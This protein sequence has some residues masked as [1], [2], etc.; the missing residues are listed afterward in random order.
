M[1]TL[2]G[3]HKV[4]FGPCR[5]VLCRTVS[6]MTSPQRTPPRVATFIV[7]VVLG[8]TWVNAEKGRVKR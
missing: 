5:K 2:T 7:A 6:L 1:P 3:V 8:T 4:P